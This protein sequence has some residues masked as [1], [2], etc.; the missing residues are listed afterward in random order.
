MTVDDCDIDSDISLETQDEVNEPAQIPIAVSTVTKDDSDDENESGSTKNFVYI[1]Q[2]KNTLS[3]IS[4]WKN[5]LI[6]SSHHLPVQLFF[7]MFSFSTASF[8]SDTGMHYC[9]WKNTQLCLEPR[10]G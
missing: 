10:N 3:L 8:L 5:P 7:T 4:V 1:T 6:L 2:G 9:S